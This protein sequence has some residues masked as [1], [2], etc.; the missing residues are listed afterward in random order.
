[1]PWNTLPS[2]RAAA[3]FPSLAIGPGGT[4]AQ[5]QLER[6]VRDWLAQRIKECGPEP[7][8]NLYQELLH[9]VEPALLD[10]VMNRV[11]GNRWLAARWLGLN[12]AT[13]RKKLTA[14]NLGKAETPEESED[15][16]PL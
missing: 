16:G 14:Y 7:P 15:E 13:V 9:C 8:T 5:E 2:C 11:Q 6:I 10:E 12:R 4:S 3:R 1:M